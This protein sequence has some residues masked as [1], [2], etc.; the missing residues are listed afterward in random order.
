MV[1]YN[2]AVAFNLADTGGKEEARKRR[3]S[4]DELV[5]LFEAMRS[6]KGFTVEN[7]L[8]V[9]LLLLL[10][11]RK[12]ELTA[13]RTAEFDPDKAVRHLPEERTKTARRITSP[14]PSPPWNACAS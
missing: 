3:L 11:V 7:F 14:C 9:M 2:P 13:A 5:Q 4:R 8:T 1:E 6:A 10:A 12:Q